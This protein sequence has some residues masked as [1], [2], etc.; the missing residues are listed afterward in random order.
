MKKLILIIALAVTTNCAF[1]QT[2]RKAIDTGK[3]D[4]VPSAT[5]HRV[6]Y[7][8]VFKRNFDGSFSAIRPVQING[9]HLGSDIPFTR[10]KTFGGVDLAGYADHDLL[11]DTARG[12]VIIRKIY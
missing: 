1:S 5:A 7:D 3:N 2:T 10:G 9:E 4:P 8:Q 6:T 11:I 12:V